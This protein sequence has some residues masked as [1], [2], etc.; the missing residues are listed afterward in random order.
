MIYSNIYKYKK[1]QLVFGITL[2]VMFALL[3]IQASPAK[4]LTVADYDGIPSACPDKYPYNTKDCAT[5]LS[6]LMLMDIVT[7]ILALVLEQL[8]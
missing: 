6:Q 2:A 3:F 4:A 7:M 1:T 5:L 8:L